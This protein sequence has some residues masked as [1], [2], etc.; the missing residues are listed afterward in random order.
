MRRRRR[1]MRRQEGRGSDIML[2]LL[3]HHH[4]RVML[5]L[6]H[7]HNLFGVGGFASFFLSPFLLQFLFD[8]PSLLL[9]LVQRRSAAFPL[10]RKWSRGRRSSRGRGGSGSRL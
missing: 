4:G 5:M 6:H 9:G 3:L 8:S 1:R 7:V 2:L 10:L